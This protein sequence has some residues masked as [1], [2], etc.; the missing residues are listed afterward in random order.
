M[1][2][3]SL[4]KR[5]PARSIAWTARGASRRCRL[6]I[7]LNSD[8]RFWTATAKSSREIIQLELGAGFLR[9]AAT[10]HLRRHEASQRLRNLSA[11]REAARGG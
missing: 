4:R 9:N 2:D 6:I 7:A 1:N 3:D 11:T 10:G 5:L 8:F